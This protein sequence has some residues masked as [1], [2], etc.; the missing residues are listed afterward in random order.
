MVD[1]D[2][3]FKEL[4]SSFFVEFIEAFLPEVIEYLDRDSIT[5]LDKETFTDVTA[6]ERHEADLVVKARF[7]GE[8]SFFL[9]HVETQARAQMEFGQRMFRYFARLY[10]KHSLPIYP[11]VIFSFDRPRRRQP[12]SHRVRFPHLAVLEFRYRVIQLNRMSWRDFVKKE[13]PA[14]TALMAK[15]NIAARD[16]VRVKLECTRLMTTLKVDRAKL[17]LIAGFVDTYLKLTEEEMKEYLAE[18]EKL[19]PS[20]KEAMMELTISWIE[21]GRKQGREE[22]REEGRRQEAVLLVSRQIARRLGA[23]DASTRER[24]SR[25]SL[26]QIESLGEALL[27]FSRYED[28]ETWLRDNQPQVSE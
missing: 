21:E 26:E 16:R 5:F 11:V 12:S 1:H 4:L 10:E 9:V 22:G 7:K 20:E 24:I 3:L 23:L 17:Q 27:D 13:N 25:L 8:D 28:L 6:G 18:V 15:M 2:R 14:T 19:A